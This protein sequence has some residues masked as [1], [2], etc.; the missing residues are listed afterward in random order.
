MMRDCKVM[1]KKNIEPKICR[2]LKVPIDDEVLI[3]GSNL[4]AG[5]MQKVDTALTSRIIV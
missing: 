1:R 3:T 5:S 2:E 4:L